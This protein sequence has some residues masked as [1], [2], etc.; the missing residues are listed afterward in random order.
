MGKGEKSPPSDPASQLRGEKEK[1]E[2]EK[3]RR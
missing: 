3:V 1:K 2:K